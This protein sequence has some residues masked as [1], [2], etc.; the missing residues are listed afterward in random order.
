MPSSKALLIA[1]LLGILVGLGLMAK[2][3]IGTALAFTAFFYLLL[4]STD[5][6]EYITKHKPRKK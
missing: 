4:T 2:S 6:G 5:L 3:L 1:L